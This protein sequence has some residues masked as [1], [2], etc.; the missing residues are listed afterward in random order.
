MNSSLL[1][2]ILVAQS[3]FKKT[4]PAFCRALSL[5][6]LSAGELALCDQ[7]ADFA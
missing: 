6:A 2:T 4:V 3:C 1:G 5:P 7:G